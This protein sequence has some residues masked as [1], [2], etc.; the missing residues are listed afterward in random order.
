MEDGNAV[1]NFAVA[2]AGF[3]AFIEDGG[4]MDQFPSPHLSRGGPFP[5]AKKREI[6]AMTH[7]PPTYTILHPPPSLNRNRNLWRDFH[8]LMCITTD[9]TKVLA[10]RAASNGV[11]GPQVVRFELDKA[12]YYFLTARG[13]DE[14]IHIAT[15]VR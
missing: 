13:L 12:P 2:N 7:D 5:V 3:R 9:R 8:L 4:A 10:T 1:G 15:K 6:A 14:L 11:A